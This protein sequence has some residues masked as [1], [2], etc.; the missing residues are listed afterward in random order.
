MAD[1]TGWGRCLSIRGAAHAVDALVGAPVE[2][3]LVGLPPRIPLGRRL[4]EGGL[5]EGDVAVEGLRV[6]PGEPLA[7]DL[8]GTLAIGPLERG[9]GLDA[10]RNLQDERPE[11]PRLCR[12]SVRDLDTHWFTSSAEGNS[13]RLTWS[14]IASALVM[15]N[16]QLLK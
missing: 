16:R 12:K 8:A 14:T 10:P 9:D 3:S 2:P 11:P 13:S 15:G 1:L 4:D 7:L 5:D 6:D